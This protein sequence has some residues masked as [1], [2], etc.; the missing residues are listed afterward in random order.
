MFGGQI[1]AQFV[2]T[3]QLACRD[4]SVQS[5]HV[6]FAREGKTDELVRYIVQRHHEGRSFATLAIVARQRCGVV[7]TASVSMHSIEEGF[8]HQTVPDIPPVLPAEHRVDLQVIPWETRSTADLNDRAAQPPDY[9]LWMRTPEVDTAL[10][11]ALSA[12]ATDLSLIGTALRPVEGLSQRAEG[13]TFTS[14]TI[15]HTLWFHRPF[16][17]DKWLLLRHHSPLIAHG[18]CFGRGDIYT[19][20]GTLVASFA[21]E[22]LLRFEAT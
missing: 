14:A 3:A 4:K 17:T 10:A 2:R 21:Q 18:R 22:G 12:Y 13:S 9:D 19:E 15:S 11:P 7:A 1:L 6:I 16:S 5:V 8:E 20:D